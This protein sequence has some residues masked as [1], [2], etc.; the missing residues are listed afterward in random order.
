MPIEPTP[1]DRPRERLWRLGAP[2]LTASELLAI[3]LG[4]GDAHHDAVDVAALLLTPANG[5]IRRLALE[6]GF[7]K[8]A[9]SHLG[10]EL[11]AGVVGGGA[12]HPARHVGSAKGQADA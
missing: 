4:T 5:G 10:H 1:A 3:L 7:G 11:G 9:P 6:H 8:G 12:G 2:A